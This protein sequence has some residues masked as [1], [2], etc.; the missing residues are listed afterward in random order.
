LVE[1]VRGHR[2]IYNAIADRDPERARDAM[3][4]HIAYARRLLPE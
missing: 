1:A 3:Q 4:Q 2:V